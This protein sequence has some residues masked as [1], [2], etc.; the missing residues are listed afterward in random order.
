ML[1]STVYIDAQKAKFPSRLAACIAGQEILH[2]SVALGEIAAGIGMLDPAHPGTEAVVQILLE[3]LGKVDPS[4]IAAP[5][6]AAWLEA[7]VLAGVLARTQHLGKDARRKLLNDALVFLGAAEAGAV[8][9]SRNAKDIDL[10]LQLRP[11]VR[12]LLYDQSPSEL[13]R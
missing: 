2:S 7:S 3:I 1:D 13:P 11:G 5:S 8:L 9:I 6:A 4:R 10:L 12:V